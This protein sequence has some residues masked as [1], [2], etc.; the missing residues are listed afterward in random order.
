MAAKFAISKDKAGKLRFHLKVP[1]GEIIAAS[2][3]YE[4]KA[5]A[6][7]GIEAIKTRASGANVEDRS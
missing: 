3:G 7:Q 2:K 4:T 6:E 5:S 1:N